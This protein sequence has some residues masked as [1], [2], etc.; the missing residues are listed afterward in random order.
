MFTTMAQFFQAGGPM[1]GVILGVL[2]GAAA[3]GAERLHFFMRTARE[4]ADRL[5][6]DVARH[7]ADGDLQAPLQGLDGND[8][9]AARLLRRGVA[10]LWEG[11]AA[12]EVRR[13][14]EEAAL[15]ELPRYGRRL[16]YLPMLA[17]VATLAGLLGTIFGLQQSF[18]AL[19]AADAATKASV[20]AAGIGQAMN[21]TAF[22]LMV[23]MPCLVLHARLGS[24]AQRRSDACDAALVRFLNFCDAHEKTRRAAPCRVVG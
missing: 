23:A 4:D 7:V 22:G 12:D 5:V 1:M 24:L 20:L 3:V 10:E 6:T 8:G 14:V 18:G 13:A 9:P 15:V 11:A 17:N 2:A 19:A 16:N 21:T